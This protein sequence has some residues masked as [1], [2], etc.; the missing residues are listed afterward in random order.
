MSMTI[1]NRSA[2]DS[3]MVF[4][5]DPRYDARAICVAI[6]VIALALRMYKLGSGPMSE[7]EAAGALGAWRTTKGGHDAGSM[8]AVS[9]MLHTLQMVTFWFVGSANAF[10]ARLWPAIC[11]S[12]V[13]FVPVLFREL[14]GSRTAILGAMYLAMSPGLV[15]SSRYGDAMMLSLVCLIA[16]VA[17]LMRFYAYDD[18]KALALAGVG[19]GGGLACGEYFIP[20]LCVTGTAVCLLESGTRRCFWR[21]VAPLLKT[22]TLPVV[23][24]FVVLATAGNQYPLGLNAAGQ[25]WAKWF[26]GWSNPPSH[27]FNGGVLGLSLLYEP[28][29]LLLGAPGIILVFRRHRVASTLMV[30]ALTGILYVG[31][32]PGR[33]ANDLLWFVLPMYILAAIVT[34]RA[35]GGVWSRSDWVG[36]GVQA[37]ALLSLGAF[38]VQSIAG[39]GV[40]YNGSDGDWTSSPYV[41]A[42]I[43]LSICV[44]GLLAVSMGW[45]RKLAVRGGLSALLVALLGYTFST[46]WR[47]N[48]LRPG[49]SSELWVANGVSPSLALLVSTMEDVS[50]RSLGDRHHIDITVVGMNKSLL[51]WAMRKFDRVEWVEDLDADIGTPVVVTPGKLYENIL[52]LEYRGQEFA[53]TQQQREIPRYANQWL[54]FLRRGYVPVENTSMV[55]W[56]RSDVYEK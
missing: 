3:G 49:D 10:L 50:L 5:V 41:I 6:A 12:L 31:L 53:I 4:S 29:A 8:L 9:P 13:V 43:V 27:G 52:E 42:L 37:M 30:M 25:A 47:M 22:W 45:S 35:L 39:Y 7:A 1:A 20:G 56:V 26:E 48:Q 54:N 51:G 24:G 19:F 17:G 32:Y 11:G 44:L 16:T 23:V 33:H 46:G 18:K 15:A 14:I 38:A 55:V 2:R 34:N 36:V 28:V 40:G 21:K